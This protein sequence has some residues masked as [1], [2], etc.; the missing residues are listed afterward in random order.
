P[1]AERETLGRAAQV[2][3]SVRRVDAVSK[4]TGEWVFG[5]DFRLPG[6][7]H[8]KAV[9]SPFPHARVVHIDLEPARRVPGVRVVV[10]GKGAPYLHGSALP[11]PPFPARGRGA[12]PGRPAGPP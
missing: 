1:P 8:G 9:R 11:P 6:M 5:A 7:L 12:P 10:T 2:G 3:Q 4:V